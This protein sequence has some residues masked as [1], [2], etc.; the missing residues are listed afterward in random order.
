MSFQYDQP[1]T[2]GF[3]PLFRGPYA[4]QHQQMRVSDAERQA[5]TDRLA[6]H[7]ADGR[8]DQAEFDER[9]G[10]AMAA[11]TRADLSGL[12]D[13]LPDAGLPNTGASAAPAQPRRRHPRSFLGMVLLVVIIVAAAHAA[14]HVVA[15]LLWAGLLVAVLIFAARGRRPR[16][17]Q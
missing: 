14:L 5:V 7:F 16:H 10:R 15:P 1:R 11:K 8:L 9:A 12:L 6:E 2:R 17:D 13:D 4:D 3:A